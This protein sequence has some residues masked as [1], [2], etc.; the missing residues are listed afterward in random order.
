MQ[1]KSQ[2]VPSTLA[3][4]PAHFIKSFSFVRRVA[5]IS[6][7]KYDQIEPILDSKNSGYELNGAKQTLQMEAQE[8]LG[9]VNEHPLA[10]IE[11]TI[12]TNEFYIFTVRSEEN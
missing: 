8:V 10:V 6:V 1:Y 5:H 3:E 12:E 7:Y 11:N 2:A 4:A 9:G